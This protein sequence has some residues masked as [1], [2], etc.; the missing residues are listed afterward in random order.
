V[1]V[2]IHVTQRINSCLGCESGECEDSS[3][4][5]ISEK[6]QSPTVSVLGL[7]DMTPILGR[8]DIHNI[9]KEEVDAT[10]GGRVGVGGASRALIHS[11]FGASG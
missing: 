8:P 5:H 9:L 10:Y 7:G 4:G 11:G 1:D 2:R 6:Q 3:S